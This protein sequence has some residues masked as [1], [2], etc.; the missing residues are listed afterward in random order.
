[1]FHFQKDWYDKR[2]DDLHKS[3]D[4]VEWSEE[5]LKEFKRYFLEQIKL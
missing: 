1:V 4:H 5:L 3:N 2:F